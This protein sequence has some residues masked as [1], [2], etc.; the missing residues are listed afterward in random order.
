M[1]MDKIIGKYVLAVFIG[2]SLGVGIT[3][4]LIGGDLAGDWLVSFLLIVLSIG[5]IV[6]T[7]LKI[8]RLCQ[9]NED[10]YKE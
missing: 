3:S 10:E 5:V 1:K 6:N 9:E 7:I 8:K 4:L 2:V